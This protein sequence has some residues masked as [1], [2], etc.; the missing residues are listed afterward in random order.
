MRR[1]DCRPIKPKIRLVEGHHFQ[2]GRGAP[3]L[4]GPNLALERVLLLLPN[5]E[6]YNV[7]IRVTNVHLHHAIAART[8]SANE[9]NIVS[10]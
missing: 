8:G 2:T 7:A 3:L 6:L 5:K 4:S 1:E 9:F 10:L